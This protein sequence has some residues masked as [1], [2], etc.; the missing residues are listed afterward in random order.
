MKLKILVHVVII[1]GLYLAFSFVLFL[2]LQV[3][4]ILGTLGLVAI[5]GLVLFYIMRFVRR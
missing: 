1:L 2:G 3:H 5:A 4:P